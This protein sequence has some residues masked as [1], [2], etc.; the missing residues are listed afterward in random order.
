[1]YILLDHWRLF[2]RLLFNLF[3]PLACWS[4]FST[5]FQFLVQYS[6]PY[7][8][9]KTKKALAN[10]L[11]PFLQSAVKNYPYILLGDGSF[12]FVLFFRIVSY[13]LYFCFSISLHACP[14]FVRF[15]FGERCLDKE[16]TSDLSCWPEPCQF[17]IL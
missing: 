13:I 3:S 17:C 8:K 9:K 15:R 10:Q 7:R 11:F 6:F 12:T 4:F 16:Y 14:G 2:K 5:Q 1:M